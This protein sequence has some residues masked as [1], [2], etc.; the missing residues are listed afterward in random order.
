M[1]IRNLFVSLTCTL[2]FACASS[3]NS[4]G[5]YTQEEINAH[6]FNMN[7]KKEGVVE[8]ESGLQYK[9]LSKTNDCKPDPDAKITVHYQMMSAKTNKIIDSSYQRGSPDEFQ[10]SKMIKGWRE[11]VPMMNIGET[12]ELYIP[13][14]LAYGSKGIPGEI[15]P[16]SVLISVVTLI[17]SRCDD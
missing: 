5:G 14:E 12:W 16:N 10:L 3:S 9:I 1:L 8:T 15:A 7:L 4:N 11:G 2:M 17:K 13:P 6:W